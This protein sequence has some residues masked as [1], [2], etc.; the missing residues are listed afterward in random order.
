MRIVVVGAG[1]VGSYFGGR[2]AQAGSGVAFLAR[3]KHLEALRDRPLRIE[4]IKGDSEVPV[5]SSDRPEELG[6]A[7]AI[8][9]AVKAWQVIQAATAITP[10]LGPRTVVVPLQNGVEAP[11]QLASV[12]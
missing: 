4:S 11:A 3:G 7:D 9:V 10:L 2:L 12:P 6:R 8:L 1:A 5:R